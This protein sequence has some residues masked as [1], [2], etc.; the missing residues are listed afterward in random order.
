MTASDRKIMTGFRTDDPT[1]ADLA[2]VVST[3][4]VGSFISRYSELARVWALLSILLRP[5]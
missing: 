3:D 4:W 2:D 1:T 5:K